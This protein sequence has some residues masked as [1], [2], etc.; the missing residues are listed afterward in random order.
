MS[1]QE[2]FAS[3]YL[4]ATRGTGEKSVGH[5]CQRCRELL[6]GLD[7]AGKDILEVGA[8]KGFVSHYMATVG[9]AR[10]VTSLDAYEGKGSQATT[11]DMN[12][13]LRDLLKD[14][15]RVDVVKSRIQAFDAERHFDLV[16]FAYSLHHIAVSIPPLERNSAVMDEAVSVFKQAKGLLRD[17][18][19]VVVQEVAPLN[20]CPI[21]AYRRAIRGVDYRSKQWPGSWSLAMK[22]AGFS[23]FRVR[24]R[25]PLNLPESALLR[26]C[27]NNRLA[28]ILTDSSYVLAARAG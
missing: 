21:P 1:E 25:L 28:S 24:Y 17:K 23:G 14:A 2:R 9:G 3:A 7:T 20:L 19:C 11:Y 13:R 4:E 26:V 10:H 15:G 5:M 6:Y 12:H 18:G 27:F 16:I 8:G 22:R